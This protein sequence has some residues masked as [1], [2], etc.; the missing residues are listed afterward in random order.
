MPSEEAHTASGYYIADSG[1]SSV[2]KSFVWEKESVTKD[3]KILDL[4]K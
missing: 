2:I 1:K 3:K 4:V